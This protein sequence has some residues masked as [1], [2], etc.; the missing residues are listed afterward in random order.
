MHQYRAHDHGRQK[1]VGACHARRP[2]D[3]LLLVGETVRERCADVAREEQV[4]KTR[5]GVPNGDTCEQEGARGA[6][7]V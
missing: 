3:G 6:V 4:E 2:F 1:D 5:H 7:A